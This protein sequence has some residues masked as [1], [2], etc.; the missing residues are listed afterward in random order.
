MNRANESIILG[1]RNT[2]YRV[3]NK[4]L[5]ECESKSD[6]FITAKSRLICLSLPNHVWS[7]YHCQILYT[8]HWTWLPVTFVG[9]GWNL[10]AYPLVLLVILL[11]FVFVY[12]LQIWLPYF[13]TQVRGSEIIVIRKDKEK[14]HS[15]C[16][17]I[18]LLF[19]F[20]SGLRPL[21]LVQFHFHFRVVYL[22][23]FFL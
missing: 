10:F 12:K 11:T 3:Y 20:L 22:C 5:N 19:F 15:C 21:S 14:N 8:S 16:Y 18:L 17:F 6:L 23:C 4:H 2:R 7:V 13:A 1:I 9:Q